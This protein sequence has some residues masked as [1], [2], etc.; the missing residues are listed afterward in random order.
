MT[1]FDPAVATAAYLSSL[2][3]EI[4]R[5][6]EIH[7]A[8]AHW[9]WAAD[10]VVMLAACWLTLR[11]NLLGR[12]RARVERRGERPW[13][14]AL[15]CSA[16]FAVIL[17]LLATLVGAV[18]AAVSGQAAPPVPYGLWFIAAVIFLPVLYAAARAAPRRWWLWSGAVFAGL[19]LLVMWVPFALASGPAELPA[20]PAGPMR[21][22]LLSLAHDAGFGVAEIYLSPSNAVDADVTGAPG[23]P[24]IAVSQGMVVRQSP[25]EARAS[26]GHLMGHYA[27]Q[28]QLTLALLAGTLGLALFYAVHRLFRPVAA[29]LGR[30]EL[31][32]ADPAGLAVA[33]MIGIVGLTLAT[34]GYDN[35]VRLINVRADQYSLDHAREPDGLAQALLASDRADRVD[36]PWAEEVLFYNHPALKSRI[37]HAMAWKAARP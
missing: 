35:V 20:L 5:A 6:A 14:A 9:L 23:R 11:F 18:G 10:V 17:I 8:T 7:T 12:V 4:R 33:A 26:V 1:G 2:P 3:P 16:V 34:V 32:P 36:P 29:A 13:I 37:A 31:S 19:A 24:R 27:H 22:A 30:G 25:Q 15:I 21:E 28:D